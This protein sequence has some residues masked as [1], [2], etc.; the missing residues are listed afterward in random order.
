MS[1]MRCKTCRFFSSAQIMGLCRRYPETQNKHER[2]WCGEHQLV[3]SVMVPIYNI[4]TDET[5]PVEM[6]VELKKRGRKPKD[7]SNTSAA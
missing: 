2:D 5:K 6:P 7:V 3:Q 1:E 4:M